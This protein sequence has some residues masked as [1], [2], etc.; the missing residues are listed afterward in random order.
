MASLCTRWTKHIWDLTSGSAKKTN[1]LIDFENIDLLHGFSKWPSALSLDQC[2]RVGTM[3][4]I[5][6]VLFFL[7]Q[8]IVGFVIDFKCIFPIKLCAI[9]LGLRTPFCELYSDFIFNGLGGLVKS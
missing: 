4:L 3:L 6:D 5:D 8:S 7:R 2:S 9:A 1:V